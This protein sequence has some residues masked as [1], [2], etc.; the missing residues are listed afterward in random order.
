MAQPPACPHCQSVDTVLTKTTPLRQ[1]YLCLTC[2][3]TWGVVIL[4]DP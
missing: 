3:G 1:D 4:P 2:R